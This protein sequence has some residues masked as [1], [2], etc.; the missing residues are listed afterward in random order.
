ML[1]VGMLTFLQAIFILK[2]SSPADMRKWDTYITTAKNTSVLDSPL[3]AV[4][5]RRPTGT[6]LDRGL[7]D[8]GQALILVPDAFGVR[9]VLVLPGLNPP[10]ATCSGF[11]KRLLP[12]A[13]SRS[14][15]PAI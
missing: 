15:S 8:E 5:N 10:P 3:L 9:F 12:L 4:V 13:T 1:A 7:A 11:R 14:L 2:A 6:T